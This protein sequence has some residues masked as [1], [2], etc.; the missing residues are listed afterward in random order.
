M[1]VV[2]T[3]RNG[4]EKVGSEQARGLTGLRT[5]TLAMQWTINLSTPKA[6]NRDY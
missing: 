1:Q 6:F 4:A 3:I 2:A 5:T